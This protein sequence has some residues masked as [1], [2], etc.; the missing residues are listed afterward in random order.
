MQP[1]GY[2]TRLTTRLGNGIV[3]LPES[4][5]VRHRQ[6]LIE[7]QNED[8]GF[9][10][11]EGDSDLYYTG[12]ALRSLAVL[13]GL[14]GDLAQKASQYLKQSLQQQAAVVDFYSLLYSCVLIQLATGE[15]L[16]RESASDWP[17][18][19]AQTLETFRTA[20]HG[21]AKTP[22]AA[23]ASTYHTFLVG[24]CY[25]LLGRS[26]PEPES[27]AEY[28]VS[29]QREDGGFVE[30]R[31][32]RRSG[33]N[34]TAAAIGTLQLI[35][36]STGKTWLTPEQIETVS[37][38]LQEM[39]S[40]EGGLRANG[41]APAADLLSTFT[42]LWTLDQLQS[43]DKVDTDS[44]RRYAESLERSDGGFHG[45]L[46]DDATDVEYT[47]YGLGTLALLSLLE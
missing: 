30:I 32:M 35:E 9:S 28:I 21:Y 13:G 41:R 44:A 19:V 22:G 37:D 31:P 23:S 40:M 27:V 26:F 8:G 20:D 2:L 7:R 38:F 5:I 25:E 33:T 3:R 16:L 29:R 1:T 14:E 43:L 18:R 34:P 11:R 42:G 39:P 36:E 45:G 4:T 17:E 12:F 46:W 6:F 10:G 15:D 24:L 47:F